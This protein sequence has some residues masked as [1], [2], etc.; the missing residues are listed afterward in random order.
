MK[1]ATVAAPAAVLSAAAQHFFF[2][3]APPAIEALL[4]RASVLAAIAT[5]QNASKEQ[6]QWFLQ[7][8]QPDRSSG[9]R[10]SSSGN[11][12]SSSFAAVEAPAAVMQLRH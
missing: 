4:T 7:Q 11:R 1:K 5:L 10:T 3:A 2:T 9:S 6:L 8:R 12:A